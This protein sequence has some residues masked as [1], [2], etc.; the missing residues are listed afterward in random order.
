MHEEAVCL[1]AED[2]AW[3]PFAISGMARTATRIFRR[4]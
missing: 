4:G 3:L 2:A 1:R